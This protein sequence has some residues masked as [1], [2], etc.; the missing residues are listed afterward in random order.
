MDT[1]LDQITTPSIS[2]AQSEQASHSMHQ[3][4]AHDH[5][6]MEH[7]SS[8]GVES[9]ESTSEDTLATTAHHSG[10][11]DCCGM[12]HCLMCN[13]VIAGVGNEGAPMFVLSHA[14]VRQFNYIPRP[15]HLTSVHFRPPISG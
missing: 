14:G 5:A 4:S 11:L 1:G 9:P 6:A 15:S 7:H 2:I 13:C 8:Y 3:V 12:G 10:K